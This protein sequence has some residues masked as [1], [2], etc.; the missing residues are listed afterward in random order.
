[1][2]LTNSGIF[3]MFVYNTF[4]LFASY[5]IR[6]FEVTIR[7][8]CSEVFII[9]YTLLQKHEAHFFSKFKN[10]SRTIPDLVE[11]KGRKFSI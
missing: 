4:P 5:S 8:N 7:K 3:V 10:K 11:E 9:V 1:M 2:D 6:L